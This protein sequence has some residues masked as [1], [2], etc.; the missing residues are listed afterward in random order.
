[1]Q[2]FLYNLPTSATIGIYDAL[3]HNLVS[4]QTL[5]RTSIGF[6]TLGDACYSPDPNV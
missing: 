5:N 1:M 3:T 2:V 6:V 4:T